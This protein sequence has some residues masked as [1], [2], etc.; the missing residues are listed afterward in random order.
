[1]PDIAVPRVRDDMTPQWMT[2]VLRS[3]GYL[4]DGRVA[5]VQIEDIGIGRGYVGQTLR[6]RSTFDG[7]APDAPE[8]VVAKIPTFVEF[9]RESDKALIDLLYSTE[10][11]WYRD[12]RADCPVRVP[13]SYWGGMEPEAGRYCLLL[14]DM[15]DLGTSD[16]L[17]GCTP[18]QAELAVTNLARI[19]ARWWESERLEQLDWL[20]TSEFQGEMARDLYALGWGAFS[21]AFESDLPA[22]F[23]SIGERI[24]P[25]LPRLYA[26]GSESA[27]TLVHGDYRIENFLFGEPG[28]AEGFVVLDWQIVGHG[29]GLRDLG[30][31][32][33]QS[34]TAE[35]RRDHEQRLLRLYH[36]TLLEHGVSGYDFD[37]CTDDYRIGLLISMF[38]PVNG[39][40]AIAE[41]LEAGGGDLSEQERAAF[42]QAMAAGK[43][44][45]QVMAERNVAAILDNDAGALLDGLG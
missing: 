28:T 3:G 4:A 38:I 31:L 23:A 35:V 16:Q 24:G 42:E 44:L 27:K 26:R 18:A 13:A 21:E 1:M 5:T 6:I 17:T 32:L 12:L 2:E 39:V 33:G 36:E 40:R 10:I 20:P 34:L 41:L 19:H 30:Y 29:S 15:G 11:Q 7:A 8:S 9:E 14:E 37:R 43:Q 25:S 45:V 22:A